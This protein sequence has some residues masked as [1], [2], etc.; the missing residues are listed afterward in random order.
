MMQLSRGLIG[1]VGIAGV[2]RG[3]GYQSLVGSA[4]LSLALVRVGRARFD[5]LGGGGYYAEQSND[6]S[7]SEQPGVGAMAGASL[8]LPVAGPIR[9]AI[10]GTYVVGRWQRAQPRDDSLRFF[11]IVIGFGL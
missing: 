6:L 10:V 9:A 7:Q 4:G 11:R 1:I 2:G 5:V 8:L 3:D